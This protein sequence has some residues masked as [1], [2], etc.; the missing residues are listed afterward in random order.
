MEK[1][2]KELCEI[3]RSHWDRIDKIERTG[4]ELPESL[5][6][7]LIDIVLD[8]L[9]VP[10][11]TSSKAIKDKNDYYSRDHYWDICSSMSADDFIS[12]IKKCVKEYK[13]ERN[14]D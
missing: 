5:K 9:G 12:Y 4:I 6:V 11:D 14:N 10:K 7:D 3:H 8:L 13:M 2:A 1:L